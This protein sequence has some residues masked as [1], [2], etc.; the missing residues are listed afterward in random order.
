MS[1]PTSPT[2][3]FLIFL[4]WIA[5]IFACAC[6]FF[7]F[8]NFIRP[9]NQ[10]IYQY[11]Q[12]EKRLKI[13][14][15]GLYSLLTQAGV[16][17]DTRSPETMPLASDETP[18][19]KKHLNNLNILLEKGTNSVITLEQAKAFLTQRKAHARFFEH[20]ELFFNT[21][22][23]LG[24]EPAVT[25]AQIALETNFMHYTGTVIPEYHNTSGLKRHD[26]QNEE[27]LEAHAQFSS[28]KEGVTAQIEHLA[29]YAGKEGYPL[30]ENTV[31]DTRHFKFLFGTAPDVLSLGAKWAPRSDYGKRLMD[32][33]NEMINQSN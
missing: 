13:K 2:S 9:I 5:F 12:E 26:V 25:L 7:I 31:S 11:Q 10:E 16:T 30:P 22:L 19:P 32:L 15:S 17:A 20:L 33:I 21:S 27:H 24:V 4:S 6:S 18:N 1:N 14:Y 8:W 29:L 28:W 23:D 3:R